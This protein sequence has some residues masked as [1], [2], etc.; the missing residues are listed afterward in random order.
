MSDG[1]LSHPNPPE[2][3]GAADREAA[4]NALAGHLS[5]G[6][7]SHA[8]YESRQVR[9]AAAVTRADLEVLFADLPANPPEPSVSSVPPASPVDAPPSGGPTHVIQPYQPPAGADRPMDRQMIHQ[10]GKKTPP[11]RVQRLLAISGGLSLVLF[12]AI[13]F[14]IGGWSWAWL[15][16]LIPG[17][18]RGYYGIQ[19]RDGGNC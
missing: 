18:I 16:F 1:H 11:E 10:P 15:V 2:L 17:L 4:A 6:R 12:F 5:A 3:I 8:E 7:L 9:A 13:G 19:D 14:G